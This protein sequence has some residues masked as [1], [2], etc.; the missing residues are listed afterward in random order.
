MKKITPLLLL[1]FL[2]YSCG[3]RSDVDFIKGS[4]FYKD[5]DIFQ[6]AG[7]IEID[8]SNLEIPFIQEYIKTD[9]VITL[10]VYDSNLEEFETVKIPA[11]DGIRLGSNYNYSDA[12]NWIYGTIENHKI[13]RYGYD[14]NPY[15]KEISSR[16]EIFLY[17]IIPTLIE[18]ITEDTIKTILFQDY[19]EDKYKI[20][21]NENGDWK[22]MKN[23]MIL[24]FEAGVDINSG[25]D[26]LKDMVHMEVIRDSADYYTRTIYASNA[27]GSDD[28]AKFGDSFHMV[29]RDAYFRPFKKYRSYLNPTRAM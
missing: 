15:D 27:Y 4:R 3:Q 6:R 14:L 8:S 16:K 2:I 20:D 17:D 19:F 10:R 18:I 9:S 28:K 5:Y 24:P 11:K 22:K 21:V 23:K 1:T 25:F 26:D 13:I 29:S 7:I 12:P